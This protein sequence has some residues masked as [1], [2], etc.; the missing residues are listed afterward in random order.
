[1]YATNANRN[2]IVKMARS[3][4]Q[5][6]ETYDAFAAAVS[7]A[8]NVTYVNKG[9]MMKLLPGLRAKVL[10]A[11][12]ENVNN[13]DCNP[14]NNGSIMFKVYGK[15]DTMLFCADNEAP[16]EKFIID[17]FGPELKADYVQC[18]HHAS[19]GLSTDFYDKVGAKK[20]CIFRWTGLSL[21]QG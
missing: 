1:V 11:W 3:G 14:C 2:R 21:C 18:G 10:H 8:V 19:T 5:D 13:T 20:R 16:I 12:D 4:T 9:D 15:Q 7:G 17:Q 6:V